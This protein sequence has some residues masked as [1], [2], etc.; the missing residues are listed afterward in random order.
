VA[1]RVS[2]S[3]A[4]VLRDYTLDGERID[5]MSLLKVLLSR[6]I[7]HLQGARMGIIIYGEHAYTLVPPTRDAALL[8][9]MVA[10]IR[11]T[12]AGRYNA[13]GEALA[14]ALREADVDAAKH[15]ER[16]VDTSGRQRVLVLL[17]AG[18]VGTGGIDPRAAA[19]LIAEQG[20][21]LYT[22]VLGAP[23][24]GSGEARDSGLIYR[25][26]GTKLLASLAAI[27]GGLSFTATDRS[28]IEQALA[29][30]RTRELKPIQTLAEHRYLPLYPWP[31]LGGLLLLTL[32][33]L[34]SAYASTH[35]NAHSGAGQ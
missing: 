3:V 17:S 31:L 24:P 7:T 12:V 1:L 26:A 29:T 16:D 2:I 15:R 5:R 22:V 35:A 8:R 34:A 18:G 20:L 32:S 23:D 11:S 13:L 6:F 33:G 27:G 9:A 30:I 25:P 28:A 19:G 4:M 14:L 21:A 10:R